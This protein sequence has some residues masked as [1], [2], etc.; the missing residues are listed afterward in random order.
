[1]ALNRGLRSNG[2]QNSNLL[3]LSINKKKNKKS[4]NSRT[5]KLLFFFSVTAVLTAAAEKVKSLKPA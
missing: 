5:I 4:M 3:G 1:M 2:F